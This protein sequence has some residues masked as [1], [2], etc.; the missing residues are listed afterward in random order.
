VVQAT[1]GDR[2]DGA[3][4]PARPDDMVREKRRAAA[5]SVLAGLALTVLKLAA[6]LTSGSL[7]LLAEAAHS[8]L[9]TGAAVMTWFAVGASWR[10]PDDEHQYGHG[11]IESLTALAETLLLVLTSLWI[12]YEAGHRLT[13]AGPEVEPSIWAFGVVIISIFVDIRRSRDLSRVARASDSQALEADALHFSTDVASSAVV[14]LGL[15]GVA[16]ARKFDLPGLAAADALAAVVVAVIVLVLS[17]KLGK[18]AADML[19]DRAPEGMHDRVLAAVTSVEGVE[20]R[21]RIRVRKAGDRAFADIEVG[22]RP[23]LPIAEGE[24]IAEE[25]RERGRRVLGRGASVLV[26]LRA[27]DSSEGVVERVATAVA[28]EGVRAHN[29]TVRMSGD[30]AH[31]DLHLE[32][33][34][35]MSLGEAHEI[36]DRVERSILA[37][38]P[39]IRRADIHLEQRRERPLD[40]RAPD[41]PTRER[42][43]KTVHEVARRVSGEDTVHDLLLLHTEDGVHLSCH[44]YLPEDVSLEAAH[45]V[46]DRLERALHEALPELSRVAVHAEPRDG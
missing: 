39:E 1:R 18:R 27:A 3:G 19:L 20:G 29:I 21:P 22:V 40:A 34:G 37:N 35:T 33:P 30:E 9:D 5:S 16:A 17:W 46:T 38:V 15:L 45:E 10:P 24:R 12:I 2:D 31:A 32:L 11:K 14:L 43:G 6:G 36:A 42:I 23:G 7:G 25:T 41:A 44:C 13:G 8:A 4:G 26:Q 28:M